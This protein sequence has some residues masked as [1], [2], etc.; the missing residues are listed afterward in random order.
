M[1]FQAVIGGAD[2]GRGPGP[3]RTPDTADFVGL[4]FGRA[5]VAGR[6]RGNV[7][8][9]AML[10]YQSDQRTG[11][12][13]L[14]VVRMSQDRENDVRHRLDLPVPEWTAQPGVGVAGGWGD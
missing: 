7:H 10:S 4:Q 3:F 1:F 5:T 11:A 12:E 8:L 13:E 2:L 14:G 9:P 6:H